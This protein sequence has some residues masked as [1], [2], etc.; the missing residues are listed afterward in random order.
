MNKESLTAIYISV[1]GGR[2]ERGITEVIKTHQ[3]W[4]KAMNEELI[5]DQNNCYDN[6]KRTYDVKA[7]ECDEIG[8]GD[9]VSIPRT[10]R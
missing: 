4:L 10:T 5:F 3:V 7:F 6:D 2:D 8:D 9:I 1:G